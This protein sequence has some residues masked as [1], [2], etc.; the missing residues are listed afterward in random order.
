[1]EIKYSSLFFTALMSTEDG[2]IL[3]GS[4]EEIDRRNKTGTI[5]I[6]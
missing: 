1:M 2:R 6:I 3:K 5:I 4:D